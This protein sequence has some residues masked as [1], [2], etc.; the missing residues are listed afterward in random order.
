MRGCRP[1]FN[2]KNRPMM[3]KLLSLALFAVATLGFA[4]AQTP[5]KQRALD[6]AHPIE[7]REGAFH[8]DGVTTPLHTRSI[9]I[10]G[11]LS[12]AEAA[13]LPHVYRTFQAAA[14]AFV[15]GTEEEPMR[16]YLAPWVY[17]IDDPD[18]P[19][20]RGSRGEYPFGMVIKCPHLH[21]IGLNPD[22]T[23]VVLASQRGQTQGAIGNFTMFDFWGD[24]LR[25]ENLT[26]G[27]F[28]N[29]DLV[30]KLN[31]ALSRPKRK[32]AITQAHVAYCHGDRIVAENVYFISRL[33]M[34]PLSGAKRILFNGCHMESTDDALCSTGVY[35]NCTLDFYGQKPFY[36]SDRGGAV[37]LGCRFRVCHEVPRQYFCKS[38]NQLAIINS[39]YTV[40]Q[41]SYAGWTHTPADWLRCYQYNVKMNGQPYIIGADKPYNTVTL[42]QRPLLAAYLLKD[43]GQT[44]Y[45]IYNLLCGEDG[46]DPLGQREQIEELGRRHKRDYTQIATCLQIDQRQAALRTGEGSLT[47]TATLSRHGN[48]PL[49]NRPIRWRVEAGYERFV[50][51]S[52]ERGRTCTVMPANYEDEP[53][54]FTLIASTDEGHEAAVELT[55]YPSLLPPPAFTEQPTLHLTNRVAEVAYALDL[56]A[57][58]DQSLVTW[59]RA[60]RKDGKDAVPVA[61]TQQEE[62]MLRY[63]LT[64]DDV[65][66]YLIAGI[67][68]KHLRSNAGEEVRIA[69]TRRIGKGDVAYTNTLDTDFA[70][71]PPMNQPK[72]AAGWWTVD[73]IK[74]ADTKAYNWQPDPA[75]AAWRYGE[76]I[77]GAVGLGLYQIQ[78]GARL[79]YTPTAERKGDMEITLNCDPAKT[80]GQGFG[81][82]TGQYMDLYIQFDT[83]TLTGYALR[84]ERTTKHSNAVDFSLVRYD[85]G[86][87]TPLT[88]PISSPCFRT[89]CTIRLQA[90][91]DQLTAHIESKTILPLETRHLPQT[92]DLAATI[93]PLPYGGT[94]L[95]YTGSCGESAVLLHRLQVSWR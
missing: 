76:S 17:W 4:A 57:R 3:R 52:S 67:R 19:Y 39:S 66:Y 93:K 20:I 94:G 44:H 7:L 33:N 84:I 10:D 82:A 49:N 46:W 90:I 80:A 75:R 91:G 87:V 71:F 32:S 78:K 74:P 29:V 45:N 9:L 43:G 59:Y 15:E 61:V 86:V 53:Q 79:L 56:G 11:S 22:P 48:Y 16:V 81:S 36:N 47:L 40:T 69:T 72:I 28:C 58:A 25:F 51:L 37:F 70:H 95:L 5:A 14:E 27:N 2:H 50:L 92:V 41:P 55:I 85:K 21:L 23:A 62:P 12:D 26:M 83:K 64:Q 13:T 68:P 18:D 6:P 35:L 60:K 24:G 38:Q 65:G 89:D 88:E 30:Y 77:N 42:D 1:F 73:C 34:N 8:Y 31:P 54:H 63:A